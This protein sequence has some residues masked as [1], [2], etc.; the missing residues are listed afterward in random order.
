MTAVDSLSRC[1]W[2][3]L[4]LPQVILVASTAATGGRFI[5]NELLPLYKHARTPTAVVDNALLEAIWKQA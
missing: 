1:E 4:C 5:Q 2:L 3:N